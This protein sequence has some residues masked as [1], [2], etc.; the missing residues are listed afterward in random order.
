[1]EETHLQETQLE[2]D[3]IFRTEID[4]EV[5]VQKLDKVIND[6][7]EEYIKD[8]HPYYAKILRIHWRNIL[9]G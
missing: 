8:G 5:S 6:V 1:M 4:W 3:P 7:C 9:K 2:H